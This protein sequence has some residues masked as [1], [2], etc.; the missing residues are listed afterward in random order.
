MNIDGRP[1]SPAQSPLLHRWLRTATRSLCPEAA[2]RV[3]RELGEHFVAAV[4]ALMAD[5]ASQVAAEESVLRSLGS[6]HASRR[7][8]LKTEPS[9]HEAWQIAMLQGKAT[10]G[11][12]TKLSLGKRRFLAAFVLGPILIFAVLLTVMFFVFD[13]QSLANILFLFWA[14]FFTNAMIYVPIV[15]S[16]VSVESPVELVP[17]L[18]RIAWFQAALCLLIALSAGMAV[19][20]LATPRAGLE[21]WWLN[22]AY[23][24][25]LVLQV[26]SSVGLV[27]VTLGTITKLNAHDAG[28]KS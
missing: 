22:V 2:E 7:R 13:S 25:C 27:S 10:F 23:A 1:E 17:H 8:F 3:K 15:M 4:E 11:V 12:F 26:F 18:R 9:K 19:G 6:A 16:P 28:M 20:L 21:H 24:I 14:F 5:G